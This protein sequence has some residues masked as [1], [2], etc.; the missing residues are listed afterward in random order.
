MNRILERL[1]FFIWEGWPLFIGALIVLTILIG[2]GYLIEESMKGDADQARRC[3]AYCLPLW[4][5]IIQNRCQCT[6]AGK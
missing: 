1:L 3:E 6:T 4:G 5:E 2:G